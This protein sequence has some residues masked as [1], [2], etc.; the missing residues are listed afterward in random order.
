MNAIKIRI[1]AIT[2]TTQVREVRRGRQFGGVCPCGAP[3]LSGD[4]LEEWTTVEEK[5]GSGS[6]HSSVSDL[7]L[8]CATERRDVRTRILKMVRDRGTKQ[9]YDFQPLI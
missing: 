5:E 9:G 3:K 4:R 1:S 6:V 7:C 8:S 2:L